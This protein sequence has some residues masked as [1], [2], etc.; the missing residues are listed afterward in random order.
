MDFN[1]IDDWNE[2]KRQS[3]EVHAWIK[4]AIT[5]GWIL[6]KTYESEDLN[7]SGTLNKN[8]WKATYV[9]RVDKTQDRRG[10]VRL[11]VWGPDNLTVILKG[12]IYNWQELQDGLHTCNY[13]K[14]NNVSVQRVS[15]AGRCCE[16]CLP[17]QRK[18]SE[19][20]GWTL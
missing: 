8:K 20:P 4:A 16:T 5:D 3:D 7:R 14:R 12:A 15:F 2:G 18:I 19:Y 13:C 11:T 9:T 17:R 1:F 6:S 10:Y